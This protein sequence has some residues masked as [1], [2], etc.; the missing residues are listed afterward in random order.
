MRVAQQPACPVVVASVPRSSYKGHLWPAAMYVRGQDGKV[1]VSKPYLH[2]CSVGQVET[3]VIFMAYTRMPEK[4][5][6]KFHVHALACQSTE[7]AEKLTTMILRQ[8]EQAHKLNKEAQAN[9]AAKSGSKGSSERGESGGSEDAGDSKS[10]DDVGRGPASPI[11]QYNTR[12][13]MA[14]RLQA[15]EV[16]RSR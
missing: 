16:A 3:Y 12:A 15:Q 1:L 4:Q 6:R 2:F 10:S 11:K 8:C 7:D 13:A 5:G 14:A 9:K